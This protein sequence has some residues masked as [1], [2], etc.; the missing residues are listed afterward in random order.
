MERDYHIHKW[1]Y[2]SL[3]NFILHIINK[4]FVDIFLT[5][6]EKWVEE[7]GWIGT[8]GAGQV[9]RRKARVISEAQVGVLSQANLGVLSH[10]Q[11][12]VLFL[13]KVEIFLKLNWESFFLNLKESFK[14]R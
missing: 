9:Q 1:I 6:S 11:V 14:L 5:I 10:S 2:T 12:W 8:A 4:N 3:S 7:D 13:V